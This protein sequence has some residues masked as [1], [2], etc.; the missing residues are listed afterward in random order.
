MFVSYILGTAY[1]RKVKV[2]KE[3]VTIT[4]SQ[5]GRFNLPNDIEYTVKVGGMGT[6]R[7]KARRAFS[8]K[9]NSP[10]VITIGKNAT[11]HKRSSGSD[12]KVFKTRDQYQTHS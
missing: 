3:S 9:N 1:R 4:T 11:M 10:S 7:I 8:S 5:E 12:I 2:I 6:K